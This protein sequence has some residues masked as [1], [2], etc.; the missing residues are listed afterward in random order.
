[1]NY[2][3]EMNHKIPISHPNLQLLLFIK[4]AIEKIMGFP[5]P[6]NDGKNNNGKNND[7]KNNDGK[8]ND[9]KNNDG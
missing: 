6:S 1:M 9:G 2:I 5:Y 7:G 8:N 3:Q 4:L